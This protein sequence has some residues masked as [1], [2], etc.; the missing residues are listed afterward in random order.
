MIDLIKA[1]WDAYRKA[2]TLVAVLVG[3]ATVYVWW[4]AAAADKASLIAASDAICEAS[5]SPF[6]P[7]GA[8]KREWGS[9][10]LTEVRR[11]RAIDVDLAKGNVETLLAEAERRAGKES[12]DAALAARMSERTAAAVQRME[13]ADAAVQDDVATGAWAG[14]VNELGGLRAPG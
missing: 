2:A 11:L 13:A 10:C 9:S 7:E 3:A 14:S 6:R 8:R 12:V 4:Q 5:G 1:K